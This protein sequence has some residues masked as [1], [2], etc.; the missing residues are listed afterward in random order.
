MKVIDD[1][2]CHD[3]IIIRDC[4]ITKKNRLLNNI[5][6]DKNIENEKQEMLK[7]L[8]YILSKLVNKVVK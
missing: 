8:D 2:T 4:V 3:Y 7:E 1:L 6:L 5:F